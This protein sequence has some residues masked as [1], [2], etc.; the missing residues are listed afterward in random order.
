[1]GLFDRFKKNNNEEKI[2]PKNE[3]NDIEYNID[4]IGDTFSIGLQELKEKQ[5]ELEKAKKEYARESSEQLEKFEK[6]TQQMKNE[7]QKEM[8]KTVQEQEIFITDISKKIEDVNNL[9]GMQ[10]ADAI[11]RE[12]ARKLL[13]KIETDKN[14]KEEEAFNEDY[15][16][17]SKLYKY[18]KKN[19]ENPDTSILYAFGIE[20]IIKKYQELSE[21]DQKAIFFPYLTE[22]SQ[23]IKNAF[24]EWNSFRK[25]SKI[26]SVPEF[27]T[28]GLVLLQE[29]Q[30]IDIMDTTK[31][32]KS[33]SFSKMKREE[34]KAKADLEI[35]MSDNTKTDDSNINTK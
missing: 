27:Y 35:M 1:M 34:I 3:V 26:L 10:R 33:F 18:V 29:L 25:E 20:E 11:A 14:E 17:I 6:D 12:E 32:S 4:E 31:F 2:E 30:L 9:P 7:M 13:N 23:T 22:K 8:D 5:R 28:R 21:Q 16:L 24:S 15:K 19:E